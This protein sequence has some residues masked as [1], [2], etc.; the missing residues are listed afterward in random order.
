MRAWILFWLAALAGARVAVADTDWR[1]ETAAKYDAL[2]LIGTLAGDSFYT[3]YYEAER[4][5][6][7]QRLDPETF[8]AAERAYETFKDA[9]V[10]AGPWLALAYSAADGDTLDDAIAATT[11]PAA[12]RKALRAAD[13]WDE[14]EWALYE[15]AREDVL[16]MLEGLADA[17][18]TAWW[19]ETADR[20]SRAR[21]AELQP[22][23]ATVDVVPVIEKAVGR[24]L[25]SDRITL[26]AAR[27]CRPHG[28]RVTGARFLLD[29]VDSRDP[30]SIAGASA[31]HEM[32]HPPFDTEDERIVRFVELVRS[33]P[34]VYRRWKNHDPSFGYNTIEGY[35]DEDVTKA[36]DQLIGE[37]VGMTFTDD[38]EERWIQNDDGMHVLAAAVYELMRRERF[39]EGDED[40]AAFLDRMIRE[41]KLAA[42]RIEA[43][44]P[45]SVRQAP[46]SVGN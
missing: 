18:F 12:M 40:A 19:R 44:V 28:I 16:A 37:R 4:A 31:I 27:F 34:F 30:L 10:L 46:S 42:G 2:C 33:D 41:G 45:E 36:I 20:P 5:E 38:V 3:R 17:E 9:G 7:R 1:I 29:I 32:V 15:R 26:Y 21:G 14:G 11:N 43:L 6:L 13:Y 24:D 35:A 8:A 39:L 23:L 22:R 25:P